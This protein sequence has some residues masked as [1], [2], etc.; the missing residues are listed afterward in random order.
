MSPSVQL[1]EMIRAIRSAR[2]QCE[3][4]G[5]IQRECAAIR[6]QFRQADNGGRSH[7]L[8]KLL[9]V[10]ML[11]YPAHFGQGCC[12]EADLHSEA[13]RSRRCPRGCRS[14]RSFLSESLDI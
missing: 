5:V 6:A 14:S 9:Y 2:T 8:A 4:R 10:H 3:E 12:S 11:G 7:N 1:Q 13:A